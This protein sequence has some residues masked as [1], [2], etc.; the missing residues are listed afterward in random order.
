MN[1]I[2]HILV[3]LISSVILP[4]YAGDYYGTLRG[5]NTLELKSPYNGVVKITPSKK[6]GVYSNEPPF[7]VESYELESRKNV[8]KIKINNIESKISRLKRNFDNAKKS[9]SLGYI[10]R[11]E[12]EAANDDLNEASINLKEL[13]L[14]LEA[15]ERTLQLGSPVINTKFIIRDIYVMNNQVVNTG[16]AILKLEN[17]DKFII[18]I[19]YDPVTM[20]GRIQDKKISVKSLV[21]GAEFEAIAGKV[22][23]AGDSSFHGSKIASLMLKEHSEELVQFLD[24]VFEVHIDD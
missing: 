8:L 20:K 6:E 9:F 15:L 23:T 21:T 3:F 24:T 12:M 16:D 5:I 4:T 10:S 22:S 11:S 14:E 18:D 13:H 17:I 1:I 2:K 19:K 7:V